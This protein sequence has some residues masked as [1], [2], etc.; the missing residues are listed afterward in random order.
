MK[1]FDI[2]I[3]KVLSEFRCTHNGV[4]FGYLEGM[5]KEREK[6]REREIE[7]EGERQTE[8]DRERE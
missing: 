3:K 4:N 2:A 6:E 7:R 8:A 1:S 5:E